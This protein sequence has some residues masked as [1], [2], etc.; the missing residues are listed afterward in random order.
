MAH[1]DSWRFLDVGSN[2]IDWVS[3]TLAIP[4]CV[5]IV[6]AWIGADNP[7]ATVRRGSGSIRQAIQRPSGGAAAAAG[8][9]GAEMVSREVGVT[10]QTLERWRSDALLQ[11]ARERIW[12]A[13]AP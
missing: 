4:P 2:F 1:G 9:C 13:A 10:V 5:R 7:G 6:V 8:E 11:P 12:T 3:Q